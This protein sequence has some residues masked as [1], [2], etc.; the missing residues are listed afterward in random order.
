M[1]F[2]NS[3]DDSLYNGDNWVQDR[4]FGRLYGLDPQYAN[5]NGYFSINDRENK[6]SF[7]SDLVGKLIVL[8]YISDGLAYDLDS[9]I[10]KMAEDA[11]YAYILHAVVAHR[12]GSQEYLVRRLQQDKTAKLRNAKIRLSNIKLEEITQVFRGKSKWIKH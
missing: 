11:M 5:M 6:I 4:F 10:P 7:S 9:R 12:S 1:N 3:L 8:E 2:E